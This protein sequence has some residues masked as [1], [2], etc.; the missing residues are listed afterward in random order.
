MSVYFLDTSA[1]V[2]LYHQEIGSD[3][4]DNFFAESDA[5]YV[6]SDTSIIEFYSAISLKIRTGQ[7]NERGFMALRR[8]FSQNIRDGVYQIAEFTRAEKYDAVKLLLKYG[9]ENSLKALDAIQLSMMRSVRERID[10]V[11]CADEKFFEVI[12]FE[13]FHAINPVKQSKMIL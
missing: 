7:I 8:L 1:L 2:K 4:I 11:L 3:I 5:R 9:K 10:T 12:S 13:G 6:I